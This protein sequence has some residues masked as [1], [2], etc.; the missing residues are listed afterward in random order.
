LNFPVENQKLLVETMKFDNYFKIVMN[1]CK[2]NY[3]EVDIGKE[4]AIWYLVLDTLF[5]IK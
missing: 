5:E 2:K 1:I 3:R 4:E